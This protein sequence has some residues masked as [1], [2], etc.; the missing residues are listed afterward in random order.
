[1]RSTFRSLPF[2]P[3]QRDFKGEEEMQRALH[4]SEHMSLAPCS[5][6]LITFSTSLDISFTDI[7]AF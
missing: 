3:S 5:N 4:F 6:K 1:M 7:E 2:A